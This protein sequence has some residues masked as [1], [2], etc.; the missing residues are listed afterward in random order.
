M[1]DYISREAAKREL[2]ENAT[3]INDRRF[4]KTCDAM[5]L[6]D[7]VPAANVRPVPD[8]IPIEE[9]LPEAFESVLLYD[10]QLRQEQKVVE[11]YISSSKD[12]SF[13]SVDSGHGRVFPTHWMPMPEPPKEGDAE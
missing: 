12:M 6:L 8:W 3:I 9:Q 13:Y 2:L 5:A 4:M 10:P 11:G 7:L 1:G